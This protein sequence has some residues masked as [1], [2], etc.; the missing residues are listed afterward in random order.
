MPQKRRHHYVPQFY[1]R[2]F[3][4]PA[5]PAGQT[6]Y[7]WVLDKAT[8]A[9][10]RRA[11]QNLAHEIGFYAITTS[12]GVDFETLENELSHI[13][14]RAAFELRRY[15]S[16]APGERGA[17]QPDLAIFISW[18]AARVPAF[19]RAA[20]EQWSD[21]L[22]AAAHGETDI[23]DDPDFR[24][25]LR[26]RAG[27][28]VRAL[29]LTEALGAIRT[30]AW[31]PILSS[32]QYAEVLRVQV[33]YFRFKHFPALAWTFLTAPDGFAFVTSD[34]PVVWQVPG[35]EPSDDPGALQH[36]E[37]QLTVPLNP[38]HALLGTPKPPSPSFGISVP[39]V[40]RR[41]ID[42]AEK[43]VAGQSAPLLRG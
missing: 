3:T 32:S 33:W 12:E 37:V 1:L 24:C 13:E 9:I 28:S 15:L 10:G 34:R 30:G 5:T 16:A 4:D 43:F 19:R 18:L 6:P 42:S 11:P 36:P 17:I 27:T 21:F 22:S 7:L 35:A 41:T 26:E 14:S 23:P 31:L 39:E 29:P 8:G 20:A 40:N 25:V 2:G 38:R